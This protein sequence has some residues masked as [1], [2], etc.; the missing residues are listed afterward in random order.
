[1]IDNTVRTHKMPIRFHSQSALASP[2]IAG[3]TRWVRGGDRRWVRGG[4]II[5]RCVRRNVDR[6]VRRCVDGV[7]DRA[8]QK[9][10]IY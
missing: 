9:V 2:V 6:C 1:M 5:R 8:S 7:G 4:S 3:G 10:Y